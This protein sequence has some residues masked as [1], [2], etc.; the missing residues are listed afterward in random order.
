MPLAEHS[1]LKFERMK[2]KVLLSTVMVILLSLGFSN[3]SSAQ[4]CGPRGYY[5]GSGYRGGGAYYGG[6]P[7][8]VV[9]VRPPVR[10]CPP[11]PA[12]YGYR[13][14]PRYRQYSYGG[15]CARGHRGCYDRGCYGGYNQR[16]YGRGGYRSDRGYGRY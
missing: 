12:Y 15:V 10:Y 1:A 13:A 9:A 5:G 11:P 14:R 16:G 7:R 8:V 2:M 4:R 6:G 3:V